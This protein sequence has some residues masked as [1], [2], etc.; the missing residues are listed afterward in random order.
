MVCSRGASYIAALMF[1]L[2]WWHDLQIRLTTAGISNT[3]L[4]LR[5]FPPVHFKFQALSQSLFVPTKRVLI[6]KYRD[7]LARSATTRCRN[8]KRR[9]VTG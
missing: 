8:L 3:L 2:L 9:C 7:S 4:A 5:S 6:T 1:L